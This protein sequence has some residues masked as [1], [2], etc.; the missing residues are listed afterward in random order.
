MTSSDE[1]IVITGSRNLDDEADD[2]N[3]PPID[4]SEDA[5]FRAMESKGISI[6]EKTELPMSEEHLDNFSRDLLKEGGIE[7]VPNEY[8]EEE[9]AFL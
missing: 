7:I 6:I 1:Y 3:P 9:E 5:S 2:S 4:E 8:K